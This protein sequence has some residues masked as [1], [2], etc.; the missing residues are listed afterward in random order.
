MTLEQLRI[1]VA[2]AERQHVTQAAQALNLT[3]SAVSAAVQALEARHDTR[4]FDRVG[5]RIALTDAGRIFLEEAKAVLAR[6][7]GAETALAELG[8]LLRGTLSLHASQTIAGY[9]LPRYLARFHATYPLIDIKLTIGNTAQVTRSVLEGAAEIGFV[10]GVVDEPALSN[11]VVA[12]DRM[13][14]V[15]GAGHPWAANGHV[16]PEELL[17]AGWVLRE[18]G[19]GTRSEFAAALAGFGLDPAKLRIEME[20]P[21]NEA[22]RTA[23]MAGAGATAI[24]ELVVTAG[25]RAELLVKMDFELPL[26]PFHVLHHK[27]RYRTKAGE[28]LLALIAEDQERRNTAP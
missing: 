22:V 4:L 3:Q 15:V 2:V 24:S 23:V 11:E 12:Q 18:P 21:S 10:E 28:A 25:I 7:A 1:F 26:R 9:W 19:S 8:G 14:V 27:S 13:V 5:R 20:L 17:T 6:A 16:A